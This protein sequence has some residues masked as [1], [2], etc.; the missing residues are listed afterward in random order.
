MPALNTH[1]QTGATWRIKYKN[2]AALLGSMTWHP[3]FLYFRLYTKRRSSAVVEALSSIFLLLLCADNQ[4]CTSNNRNTSYYFQ[5]FTCANI[6][7]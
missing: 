3:H 6:C 5:S 4:L 7:I 2:M 1:P